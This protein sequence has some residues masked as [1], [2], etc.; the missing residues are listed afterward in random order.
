M[1]ETYSHIHA[2]NGLHGQAGNRRVVNSQG[3]A[4]TI[5]CT[6]LLFL[7]FTLCFNF[8]SSLHS[9]QSPYAMPSPL[10]LLSSNFITHKTHHLMLTLTGCFIIS[11]CFCYI[12]GQLK[13]PWNALI[14][15]EMFCM[16]IRKWKHSC[17]TQSHTRQRTQATTSAKRKYFVY[18]HFM[19]FVAY[20]SIRL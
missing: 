13:H 18:F 3:P 10:P 9:P 4:G 1:S 19:C 7:R 11:L 14:F 12:E 17:I 8:F 15:C 5:K 2:L 6:F 20:F 16:N